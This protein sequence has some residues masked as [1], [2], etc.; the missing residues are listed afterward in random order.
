MKK[1]LSVLVM[2]SPA[3][4][5]CCSEDAPPSW[6]PRNE[7]RGVKKVLDRDTGASPDLYPGVR[8]T[9]VLLCPVGRPPCASVKVHVVGGGFQ[10]VRL[11]AVVHCGR[12]GDDLLQVR[13]VVA[14]GVLQVHS[15]R[16]IVPPA[17]LLRIIHR[18]QGKETG[19]LWWTE[20]H[21]YMIKMLHLKVIILVK[22]NHD[23]KPCFCIFFQ[24]FSAFT[25][26]NYV[27]VW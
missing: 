5:L 18:L 23:I 16:I 20:F 9:R 10:S 17:R 6:R 26:C 14:V 27:S 15:V 8:R 19:R 4:R 11:G 12:V 13:V 1:S 22:W 24:Q 21:W 7:N 25:F 3:P 2:Y